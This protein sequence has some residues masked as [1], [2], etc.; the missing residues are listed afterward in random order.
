[1]PPGRTISHSLLPMKALQ[2]LLIALLAAALAPFAAAQTLVGS[3]VIDRLINDSSQGLI[4]IYLG[5]TQPLAG[6]GTV[7][8]WSFYDN[9]AGTAGQPVTPLL[10]QRVSPT[11]WRVVGFGTTRFSTGN[12]AQTHPFGLLAGTS[13]LLPGVSYTIGFVHRTYTAAA[14]SLVAGVA[15]NGAVDFSGYNDF[16]DRWAYALGTPALGQELADGPG[17]PTGSLLLDGLGFAGRIY[18]VRFSV[19]RVASL[20]GCQQNPAVLVSSAKN[21]SPGTAFQLTLTAPGFQSG[22]WQIY[23]GVPGTGPTGC[24]LGLP[25]LGE[26]LLNPATQVSLLGG[27]LVGGTGQAA[28]AIPANPA[29][30]GQT[31]ALQGFGVSF[32]LPGFPLQLS[33]A[34]AAKILP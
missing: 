25:G 2:R 7:G 16:S 15:G 12:G 5:G 19:D 32:D 10:F 9:E 24:G 22:L 1:M 30:V 3:P 8:T 31:V 18:S 4:A 27:A 21:F 13:T 11:L 17:G 20:A 23:A 34:L 6:P 33:N 14:G 28:A 26:L 29:L